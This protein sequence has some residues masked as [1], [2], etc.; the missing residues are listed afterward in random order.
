MAQRL[1]IPR[2]TAEGGALAQTYLERAQSLDPALAPNAQ[3]LQ[4]WSRQAG[5][6]PATPGSMIDL[7]R[8]A[9]TAYIR[10]DMDDYYDHDTAKA[11]EGWENAR[12]L[13]QQALDMAPQSQSD[14]DYGT[15]V[16]KANLT[17]GMIVMRV[18]GNRKVA[19][20][21]LLD[22]SK[23]PRTDELAYSGDYFV[24]KL[25]VLLLKYGGLD[26]RE[27]VITF[28]ETFGK[29]YNP[30]DLPLLENAAQLRNG[31]MPIWYQYQAAQLK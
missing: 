17:L 1:I 2:S 8:K 25:P 7:A 30:P 18:D 4:G 21:Y 14:P 12:K 29:I 28:L 23:A 15:A 22:A 5:R 11:K 16:C 27:A 20:R 19:T 3:R 9:E 13:A 24:M 31:Y 10:A 6:T 26:E